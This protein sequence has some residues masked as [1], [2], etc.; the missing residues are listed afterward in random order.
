MSAS[1]T[2]L[3]GNLTSD[4]ELQFTT[5]GAAKL[6][7]S[8]AVNYYWNDQSGERQEKTSF[9][10]IVAWR[11][12]AEDG[13]SVLAKG[14]R[15]VVTGRLEQRTYE[16]KEG[17]KRSVVELIADDIAPSVKGLESVEWKARKDADGGAP[18]RKSAPARRSAPA[19]QDDE[20][21]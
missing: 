8:I 4:P 16:T 9:F 1:D 3:I 21:F 19:Q 6:S 17:E 5:G 18:A 13:A 15:V 12:L 11:Q 10:N 20:P 7:F 14:K 2:T